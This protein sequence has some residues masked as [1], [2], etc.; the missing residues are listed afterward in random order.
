MNNRKKILFFWIKIANSENLSIIRN[1]L[2]LALP[3]VIAGAA[4]VLINNFPVTVYQNCM[5]S[6]FGP[7][8]RGFGGYVWNGT[9]AILSPVMTFSIGYGIAE[10][11]NLKNPLDAVHPVI[12]GLLSFCSL[13]TI[14]E[15]A[16]R[17]FAIP[18]NWVGVNGLF[19]A[20]I[21][22]F[23]SAK[24]FLLF[25]RIKNLHIRFFSEDAGTAMSHVLA[26]MVPAMITLGIFALF[27]M[28]MASIGVPD[29]HALIYHYIA[30]P[31]KGLGNNLG[32][33]LLYTLT[34]QILW[35]FGIHGANALEPVM[36]EIY[37]PA[38][39]ANNLAIASGEA[40]PYIFT[41]TFFDTYTSMGGAGNTLSLLA[42]LFVTR[43]KSG[44]KRIAEISLLPAVFNI[45]EIL[46]FGIPIVLN[47]IYLIPFAAVPLVLTVITWGAAVLGLLPA[48]AVEVAW[49]T[50][51]IISGYAAAGS[52][53]GSIMQA[54]NIGAGF[55]L[56]LPFVR[57]AE[58]VRQYRFDLSYG[59]L[60]RAGGEPGGAYTALAGQPGET[61]AISRVLANDLLASIKKNEHLVLKNTPGITFMLDMNMRFVLGSEKTADFLGYR[62]IRE[63]AGLSFSSL[64]AE[65]MPD[66]WISGAEKRCLQVIETNRNEQYEEKVELRSGKT[67]VFQIGITP[68]QENGGACHGIVLVMNDVSELFNAREEAERASRAKGAFLANMSHEMRTPMN[69][70]IGM[71]KI[72]ESSGDIE[73]KDYCLKK[74]EDASSHLLGVINDILDISKIEANKLELSSAVFNFEKMIQKVMSVI[75]FRMDEK[76]QRFTAYIDE[77]IPAHLRGD[78]QRLSQVITNLLS[79][80]VKFTPESGHIDLKARLVEEENQRCTIQVEVIDSGIG[81]SADQLPRLFNSFAQADSGTSRRFGGT[82]LGLAISK[83]IVEMMDGRI[84]VESEPGKG[85]VFAFT[86]R[87]LRVPEGQS[88]KN[89]PLTGDEPPPNPAGSLKG[90]RILLVEDVEINREIM[91]ALLEP[92]AVEIDSAENG[93]VAL[94][95]FTESPGAYDLIFMDVQMPE[96]D[97][98]EATRRIRAWEKERREK[99]PE[100]PK[101]IPIIAMTANVFREDVEKCLAAGM[102]GHVGKPLDFAEVLRTIQKYLPKTAN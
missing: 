81:I 34:R 60:L 30:F 54:V 101:E 80:A 97:G 96:M 8:W 40:P 14:L 1:A 92:M 25:Y 41:K 90:Y 16:S 98:Y 63:M 77:H 53:A 70:I 20:I 49:T 48:S 47:P 28:I 55:L 91:M 29:I 9:L 67:A 39:A 26:A 18:Y 61:G 75:N 58:K 89:E 86:V 46:L 5:E 21:T 83:N 10:R 15:P 36:T 94:R 38:A 69:A 57:M 68:A 6:L 100:F 35:F 59:E 42:A 45:N 56:Y 102:N 19:L 12:S 43:K 52:A 72:A 76:N 85:S 93:A 3:V 64:F 33:A 24:V 73:R 32:T 50:P 17:D 62:G 95:K 27:K 31:F 87:M 78:E 44:V 11:Y 74:I 65:T 22:G 23:V 4:A 7:G 66:S 37:L 13:L 99:A 84:W 71:T 2:T 51:A 79:N 88:T 82:G